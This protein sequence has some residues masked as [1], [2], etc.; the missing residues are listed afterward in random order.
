MTV[1]NLKVTAHENTYAEVCLDG[2]VSLARNEAFRVLEKKLIESGEADEYFDNYT[3]KPYPKLWEDSKMVSADRAVEE[4]FNNNVYQDDNSSAREF[5]N[6]TISHLDIEVTFDRDYYVELDGDTFV[7]HV[8]DTWDELYNNSEAI[9]LAKKN[10]ELG[11]EYVEKYFSADSSEEFK[12]KFEQITSYEWKYGVDPEKLRKADPE[13][14]DDF[15][16]LEKE[17]LRSNMESIIESNLINWT[18]VW[19]EQ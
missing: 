17:N 1:Y 18:T 12:E 15:D 5:Y 14:L 16:K 9:S 7:A 6:M 3:E 13:T 10:A 11:E 19:N 8:D 4:W 2:Y